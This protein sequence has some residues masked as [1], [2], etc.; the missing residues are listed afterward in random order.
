MNL[1]V[2]GKFGVGPA[3]GRGSF[4]LLYAGKNLKSN[5]HVAIKLEPLNSATPVLQYEATIG[6]NLKS[7]GNKS[8][9]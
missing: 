2:N 6:K 4:G 9:M 7:E 5:E 3:L 1:I 8:V